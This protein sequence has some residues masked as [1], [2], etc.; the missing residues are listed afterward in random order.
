MN[1]YIQLESKWYPKAS[2]SGLIDSQQ[3]KF[4]SHILKIDKE[5]QLFYNTKEK[6]ME[7]MDLN[8][9]ISAENLDDLS[10][11]GKIKKLGRTFG[12]FDDNY[13]SA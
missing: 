10:Y 3:S 13:S 9:T 12:F 4:K 5:G 6:L 7:F 1:Q 8:K 2:S 11:I